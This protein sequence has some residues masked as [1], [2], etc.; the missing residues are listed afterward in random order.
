MCY[1]LPALLA[2][3]GGITLVISPLLSLIQ[4]DFHHARQILLPHFDLHAPIKAS[5][6]FI[7]PDRCISLN[8]IRLSLRCMAASSHSPPLTIGCLRISS[9][10]DGGVSDRILVPPWILA[11]PGELS[12]MTDILSKQGQDQALGITEVK[13]EG[14]SHSIYPPPWAACTTT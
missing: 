5:Y 14:V 2:G 13:V 1:Q 10:E 9:H 7:N 8:P 3:E 6:C 11:T 12:D 4:V